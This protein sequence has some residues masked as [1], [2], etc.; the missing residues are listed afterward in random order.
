MKLP[1][2]LSNSMI[3]TGVTVLQRCVSFFLLPLYTTYLT[4]ADYGITGVV[5]SVSGLLSIFTTL[6]LTAACSRFY[7]KHKGDEDYIKKLY[8]TVGCTILINSVFFGCI[9]ILAHKLIVDPLV[10]DISFYPYVFLGLMNVLVTPIYTLFQGYLQTV[11]N[12]IKFGI[13]AMLHFLLQ[14]SLTIYFVTI[15]K[16][17]ALGVLIANLITAVAFFFYVIF[18]FLRHQIIGVDKEILKESYQYSLPLLP[19][20]IA[21]W[22]NGTI[23]KLLV[24]GI[25][26]EDDAGLYNLGQQYTTVMNTITVAINSAYVPWFYDKANKINANLPQV[27]RMSEMINNVVCLI[28]IVLSLFSKEI[29]DIM[30]SNPAYEDVW[31][32][33]P[34]IIS[35]II[36]NSIYFFYVNVLFL[37]DTGAI[38][39]ITVSAMLINVG[40]NLWLIPIF[41]YMGCGLAVLV[42][43]FT[44]SIISMLMSMNKNKEIRFRS[45]HLYTTGIVSSIIC[46]SVLYLSKLDVYYSLFVKFIIILLL[47]VILLISYKSEFGYLYKSILKKDK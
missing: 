13:N 41:G 20:T 33:I 6:G 38:F 18:A 27:Q 34:L 5:G 16:I 35:G 40:L 21:N 9:F 44:K 46:M 22:S 3:Y 14:V 12:G 28:A 19:H 17:G 30:I 25:R 42:T 15:L 11:Q 29:L 7:Y 4:P 36:F 39:M 47:L 10:G 45:L 24:N 1:K 8:G 26:S 31:R 32:V 37:R 43:Y 2:I 23:D